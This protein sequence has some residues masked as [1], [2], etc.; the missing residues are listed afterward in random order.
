[1]DYKQKEI[2][3]KFASQKVE[4]ASMNKVESLYKQLDK[5]M[6]ATERPAADVRN[7]AVQGEKISQDAL[8]IA[9]ELKRE[10]D[11]VKAAA[12]EL[13]VDIDID[14][15]ESGLDSMT[16]AIRIY[17]EGYKVVKRFSPV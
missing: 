16:K 6:T 17:N 10:I 15:Y 13:G 11:D 4:L 8:N 9:S 14:G 7:A 12:K 5:L 2:L 1:M 3:Q